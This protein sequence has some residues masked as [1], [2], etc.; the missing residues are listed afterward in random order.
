MGVMFKQFSFDGELSGAYG[1]YISGTGVYNAPVK[2]VEMVTIPGRSG[3][4]ALDHKRFD[5]IE[6][7]YPAGIYGTDEAD[8]ADKLRAARAWLC[9]KEG[10]VRLMDFYNPSE[11]RL[12]VYKSGLDVNTAGLKAAEFDLVFEC[13]PQRYLIQGTHP[14]TITESGIWALNDTRFPA[15]PLLEVEG[16]GEITIDGNTVKIDSAPLG[17]I[18]LANGQKRSF[19]GNSFTYQYKID[20]SRL[21]SGD[22]LNFTGY[23]KSISVYMPGT[24]SSISGF[25]I[26]TGTAF[27][28]ASKTLNVAQILFNPA[29]TGVY[30]T[31]QS[32]A[33]SCQIAYSADGSS[34][35]ATL[36]V[37]MYLSAT[38]YVTVSGSI[39][40]DC[41]GYMIDTPAFYGNSSKTALGQPLYIDCD[42]GEAYK[43]E[44]D[45][46]V[47]VNAGVI[48][49]AELPV[50]KPGN[51][52]VIEYDN[53]I[54]SLKIT[55]RTWTV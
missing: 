43:V 53:T 13:K 31:A 3:A 48:L 8:F 26:V 33:A 47:S 25:Q 11:Y 21:N 12:A 27:Q 5:N 6:V 10:Y 29:W 52:I 55:P 14:V 30:G 18:L 15:R 32:N 50:L 28:S 36:T 49:G 23:Q 51:R 40:R 19:S 45:Q 4:F 42:L 16:Y 2:D 41:N 38:G 46:T 7:T 9:S 24:I 37:N 1:L 17:R 35:T 44:N 54:T 20:T 34:K 39:T 22:P